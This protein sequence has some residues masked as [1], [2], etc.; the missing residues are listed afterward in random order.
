M[1]FGELS[2]GRPIR[3]AVDC[4]MQSDNSTPSQTGTGTKT[5]KTGKTVPVAGLPADHRPLEGVKEGITEGGLPETS[6]EPNT[7]GAT[8]KGRRNVNRGLHS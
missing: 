2:G 5:D 3:C 8:E 6:G 7:T 1:G 4:G